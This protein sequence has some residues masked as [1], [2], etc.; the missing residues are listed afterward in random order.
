MS[1]SGRGWR[2]RG[3]SGDG[4]FPRRI[5]RAFESMGQ[6]EER[7][8]SPSPPWLSPPPRHGE[9]R[10]AR[11]LWIG[12]GTGMLGTTFA[13]TEATRRVH[14]YLCITA[15]SSPRTLTSSPASL[16]L[17]LPPSLSPSSSRSLASVSRFCAGRL[18]PTLF[19]QSRC[20][21]SHPQ[22]PCNFPSRTSTRCRPSSKYTETPRFNRCFA[23]LT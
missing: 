3:W 7:P 20:R 19:R 6:S 1:E 22:P 10:A 4:V 5:S 15:P 13:T 23:E 11:P 21:P 12:Q 16:L 9:A 17:R 18:L 8:S 14:P 2:A